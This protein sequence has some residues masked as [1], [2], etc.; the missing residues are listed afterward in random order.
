MVVDIAML[1]TSFAFAGYLYLGR[2]GLSEGLLLAQLLL[3]VFLTIALYNGAYSMRALSNPVHGMGRCAIALLVS[4]AVVV[5]IAFYTKS[6][7]DF[8]ASRSASAGAL[9]PF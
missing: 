2:H 6:S 5:F 3:P 1:A 4:S 9:R 7:Q 8:H